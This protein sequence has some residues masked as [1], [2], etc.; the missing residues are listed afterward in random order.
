MKNPPLSKVVEI[1]DANTSQSAALFDFAKGGSF[2]ALNRAV[3]DTEARKHL[4]LL[5]SL[6]SRKPLL[7]ALARI[8]WE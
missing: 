1:F 3:Y 7:R 4:P 2:A 5:K 8:G 6:T